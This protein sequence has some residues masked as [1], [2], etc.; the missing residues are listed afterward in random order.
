[1]TRLTN[2]LR[3]FPGL[4]FIMIGAGLTVTI[5]GAVIGVPMILYGVRYLLKQ[6]DLV[7]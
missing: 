3:Y 6:S 2:L 5:V 4:L 1:M 7:S